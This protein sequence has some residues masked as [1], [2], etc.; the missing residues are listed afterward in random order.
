MR[1]K[2]K[3]S[4]S[5]HSS[6][7]SGTSSTAELGHLFEESQRTQ[8][9]ARAGPGALCAQAM[10][11]MERQMLTHV[12][13]IM[14]KKTALKA[15]GLRYFPPTPSGEA[16]SCDGEGNVELSVHSGLPRDR[17]DRAS[18]RYNSSADE[19]I[20]VDS[21][22]RSLPH[23]TADGAGAKRVQP[24]CISIRGCSSSKRV[25]RG[26][27]NE[28][29]AERPVGA[30][31]ME[32]QQRRIEGQDRGQE[33]EQGERKRQRAEG[34]REGKEQGGQVTCPP[35]LTE[36]EVSDGLWKLMLEQQEKDAK[37]S[38]AG[39][40]YEQVSVNRR[41]EQ[42]DVVDLTADVSR[43]VLQL[44]PLSRPKLRPMR[45]LK[46]VSGLRPAVSSTCW[47]PGLMVCQLR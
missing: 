16:F 17:P 5:G 4:S 18:S 3:S 45:M 36:K 30:D 39:E 44:T 25:E 34:R 8:L 20:R 10:K 19:G 7:S 23:S 26:V 22:R 35:Y 29:N 9:A 15:V 1:R 13:E 42:K 41:T 40:K 43:T 47:K 14:E 27:Q 28:H 37:G 46:K 11:H 38:D 12:G 2:G 6:G 21:S 24:P 31:F 32:R 33:Q